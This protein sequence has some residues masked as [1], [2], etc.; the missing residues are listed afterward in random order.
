MEVWQTVF[1]AQQV[2]EQSAQAGMTGEAVDKLAREIIQQAGYGD[3]FGHGLGH[4]VGL[5]IH[6]NPRFSFTYQ[7]E[8]PG[9]S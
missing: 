2:A 4:S 3:Y 6:E 8:I 5:A 7:Q 1:Q 9:C